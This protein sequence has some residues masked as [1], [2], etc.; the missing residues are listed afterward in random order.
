MINDV[1]GWTKNQPGL[2]FRQVLRSQENPRQLD[3]VASWKSMDHYNAYRKNR[4]HRSRD[5]EMEHM[6]IMTVTMFDV[7]DSLNL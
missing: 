1:T 7:E 4:P 6:D 2:I 3:T 5:L